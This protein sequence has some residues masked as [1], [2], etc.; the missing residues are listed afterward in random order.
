METCTQFRRWLGSSRSKRA[1]SAHGAARV[2]CRTPNS[3][4]RSGSTGRRS[5]SGSTTVGILAAVALTLSLASC[6]KDKPEPDGFPDLI[7]PGTANPDPTWEP[8]GRAKAID[9]GERIVR[10]YAR[11]DV[12]YQRWWAD[13]EPMLSVDAK[14]GYENVDPANIPPLPQL[15]KART[16]CDNNPYVVGVAWKTAKGTWGVD[17]TRESLDGP[18]LAVKIVLP[19]SH[20]ALQ[21][22][23]GDGRL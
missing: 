9:A 3:R 19:G 6:S 5:R 18:W 1:P 21:S 7:T 20:S 15:G 22:C 12:P 10:T 2:A 13:L 4:A 16:Y 8:G 23:G 14:P 11:P 17:L